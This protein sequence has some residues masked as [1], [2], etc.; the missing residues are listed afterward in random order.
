MLSL[1]AASE[2]S[3]ALQSSPAAATS[4]ASSSA[5][6]AASAWCPS[7]NCGEAGR[8]RSGKALVPLIAQ[9]EAEEAARAD[10]GV[11]EAL[12][13]LDGTLAA[14]STCCRRRWR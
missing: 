9:L 5:S 6:P 10:D 3:L 13:I 14:R 11:C 12:R 7:P 2:L 4:A 8:R 1:L